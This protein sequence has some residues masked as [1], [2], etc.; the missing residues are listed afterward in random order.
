M[1]LR[2][3]STAV[4]TTCNKLLVSKPVMVS[5]HEQLLHLCTGLHFTESLIPPRPDLLGFG[6]EPEAQIFADEVQVTGITKD[7][8]IIEE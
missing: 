6:T 7:T 3:S 4:S 2:Q 5:N 1:L 8:E